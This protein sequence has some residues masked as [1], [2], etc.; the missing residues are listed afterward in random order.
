LMNTTGQPPLD[1]LENRGLREKIMQASLSRNSRGGEFDNREIVSRLARL[2]AERAQLLG[3]P[4]HA[5][6]VIEEQTAGTVEAVNKLM[7]QLAPAAVA[8]AKREAADLQAVI[9]REGGG[10]KLAAHDWA[11][12]SE[13]VRKE[14]YAFDESE[15]RPYFEMNR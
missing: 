10:F 8:N 2:R 14:R 12:Y 11:L 6:F 7:L 13:K 1:S 3:Y 15:L 5:A 9:D 4:N